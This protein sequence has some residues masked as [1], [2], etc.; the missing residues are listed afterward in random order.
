M[1]AM[2]PQTFNHN[3]SMRQYDETSDFNSDP[4]NKSMEQITLEPEAQYQ[5]FKYSK[6]I[7][8]QLLQSDNDR[9]SVFKSNNS[10]AFLKQT[11]YG[12]QSSQRKRLFSNK[13]K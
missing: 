9:N 10:D 2:R 4:V 8:K 12:T 6:R 7:S 3:L 1:D 5:M 11:S 13:L